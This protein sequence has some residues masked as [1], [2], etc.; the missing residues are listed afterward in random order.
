MTKCTFLKGYPIVTQESYLKLIVTQSMTDSHSKNIKS[1]F[2]I[3][4]I[5]FWWIFMLKNFC[6]VINGPNYFD[7]YGLQTDFAKNLGE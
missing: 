2:K 1:R 6:A 4:T 7:G 3:S 5:Y